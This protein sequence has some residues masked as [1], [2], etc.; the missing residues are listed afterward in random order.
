MSNNE[1]P[2]YSLTVGEFIE[3][4]QMLSTA[5]RKKEVTPIQLIKK[6]ED[7]IYS[8]QAAELAGYTEKTLSTKKSRGQIPFVSGG[9]PVTY[10][11][12]QLIE[13]I[14]LGRPTVAEM[15]SNEFINSK[16]NKR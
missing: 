4:N 7:L 9:R 11:R 15:K 14:E 5:N 16:S 6:E 1:R 8:K 2:L 12:K 13:W 3:L 10:S